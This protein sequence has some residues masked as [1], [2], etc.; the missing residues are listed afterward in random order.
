MVRLVLITYDVPLLFHIFIVPLG[1][2]CIFQTKEKILFVKKK[3]IIQQ[4][5]TEG[6]FENQKDKYDTKRNVWRHP[7]RLFV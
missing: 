5:S 4:R 6:I 3:K 2:N 1:I 7:F